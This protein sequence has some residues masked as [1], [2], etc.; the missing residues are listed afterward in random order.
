MHLGRLVLFKELESRAERRLG[1]HFSAAYAFILQKQNP[2]FTICFTGVWL[3]VLIGGQVN[4]VALA[5]E[6][7]LTVVR[8]YTHT[9]TR[10]VCFTVILYMHSSPPNFK[11]VNNGST[12]S[13]HL[14]QSFK[15][16]FVC[17]QMVKESTGPSLL[18]H[19][20]KY[21]R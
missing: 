5:T 20:V 7:S 1:C 13:V 11:H 8:T 3:R 2:H 4:M 6:V 12:F 17:I 21:N 19:I 18:Q 9:H 16:P 15:C 10:W 14:I